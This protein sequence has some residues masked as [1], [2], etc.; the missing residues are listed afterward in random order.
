MTA[1]SAIAQQGIREELESRLAEASREAK[2]WS[3]RQRKIEV[4]LWPLREKPVEGYGKIA[5]LPLPKP[6]TKGALRNVEYFQR[7]RELLRRALL[8]AIR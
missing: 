3:E 8:E 6:R 1:Y 5:T 4:L 2:R 7:H